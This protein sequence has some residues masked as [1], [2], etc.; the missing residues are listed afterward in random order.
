MKAIRSLTYKS[1]ITCFET[2]NTPTQTHDLT[3]QI[4]LIKPRFN[5]AL[6]NSLSSLL[7]AIENQEISNEA[8]SLL[9]LMVTISKSP[10][11]II[12]L[13]PSQ[14]K[15]IFDCLSPSANAKS[16]D[17]VLSF[18][19]NLLD[20]DDS[21]LALIS[22]EIK[23]FVEQCVKLIEAGVASDGNV[24]NKVRMEWNWNGAPHFIS[25]STSTTNVLKFCF[26]PRRCCEFCSPC[27]T[28]L[29]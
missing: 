9:Q 5:A 25:T 27:A 23:L 22:L 10:T 15:S 26:A 24:S 17:C 13:T 20:D 11:T 2:Y 3:S 16:L 1:F 7:L 6:S 4:S 28:K 18:V 14:T 12:L 8:P 21:G 29:S 19:E